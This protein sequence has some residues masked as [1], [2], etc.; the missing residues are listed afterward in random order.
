MAITIPWDGKFETGHERID[1]EHRIFLGLIH[2]LSVQSE[3]KPGK[4]RIGRTLREI[5]K[6]ADFHFTSEENIMEDV[7][8]PDFEEHKRLH[9]MLMVQLDGAIYDFHHGAQT[10]EEIVSFLFQWFALHTTREDK[11]VAEFVER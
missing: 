7:G 11:R 1:S 9:Q 10:A 4:E 2:E 3:T 8:Y 5:R 6:Y